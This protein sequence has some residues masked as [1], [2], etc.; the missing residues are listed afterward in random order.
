MITAVAALVVIPIILVI[1]LR[2]LPGHARAQLGIP[3]PAAHATA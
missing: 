2:D 3:H 1:V